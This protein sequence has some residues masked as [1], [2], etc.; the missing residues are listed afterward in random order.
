MSPSTLAAHETDVIE[1]DSREVDE[2]TDI[3]PD[4]TELRTRTELL[5]AGTYAAGAQTVTMYTGHAS[6]MQDHTTPDALIAH[7]DSLDDRFKAA[8][9]DALLT[10][11]R[12]MQKGV[13]T[14]LPENGDVDELQ[15]LDDAHSEAFEKLHDSRGFDAIP[16]HSSTPIRGIPA[17]LTAMDD[18]SQESV[19]ALRKRYAS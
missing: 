8:E 6:P 17:E 3:E 14:S 5:F 1:S 16:E 18:V 11:L 19:S 2:S 10:R 4:L 13:V 9:I 15:L 12:E 7:V